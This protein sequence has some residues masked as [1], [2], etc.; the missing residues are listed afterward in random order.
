MDILK[1]VNKKSALNLTK[2]ICESNPL[3]ADSEIN[4]YWQNNRDVVAINF[5]FLF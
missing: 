4:Q 3:R 2:K 5:D 1:N